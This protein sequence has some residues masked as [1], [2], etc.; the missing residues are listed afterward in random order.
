MGKTNNLEREGDEGRGES[1][2][3]DIRK[4]DLYLSISS[5][6]RHLKSNSLTC[7]VI[8]RNF[9]NFASFT[10]VNENKSYIHSV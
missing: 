3:L 2:I 8:G 9:A 1:T 10:V 6:G 5:L 7:Y 4:S